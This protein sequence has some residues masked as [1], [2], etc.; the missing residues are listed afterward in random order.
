MKSE[1]G[2]EILTGGKKRSLK[3]KK[4]EIAE[5]YRN[6]GN[7]QSKRGKW[8]SRSDEEENKRKKYDR[9]L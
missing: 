7:K 6:I 5:E 8:S 2:S 1:K 4:V 9:V 3:I